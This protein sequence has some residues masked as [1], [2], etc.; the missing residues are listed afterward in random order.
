M[1]HK[2]EEC[3]CWN[4]VQHLPTNEGTLQEDKECLGLNN[5]KETKLGRFWWWTILTHIL[6]ELMAE[7]TS[8]Q[9][10]KDCELVSKCDVQPVEAS[11]QDPHPFDTQ[12]KEIH[13]APGKGQ[14][15]W[16]NSIGNVQTL[17]NSIFHQHLG[18]EFFIFAWI[19]NLFA[20]LDRTCWT[21]SLP[22]T[23][24]W[25]TFAT[26]KSIPR[27]QDQTLALNHLN[28]MVQN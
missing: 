23:S 2:D 26:T 8:L 22:C 18:D 13:P 21:T 5:L 28:C 14:D 24:I 20:C 19:A 17:Q 15:M 3:L 27:C 6:M 7:A 4:N 12:W 1:D 10:G 16:D 11:P 25:Q 9:H